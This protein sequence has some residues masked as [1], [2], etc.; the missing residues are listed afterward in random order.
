MSTRMSAIK[1]Y[2]ELADE[3]KIRFKGKPPSPAKH[4]SQHHRR[5]AA[6][7]YECARL[8]QSLLLTVRCRP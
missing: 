8:L 5:K 6:K 2:H 7:M 3:R 4:K 1:W